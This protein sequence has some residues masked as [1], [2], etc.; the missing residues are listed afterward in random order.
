MRKFVSTILAM[1][2]ISLSLLMSP[3]AASANEQT[4]YFTVEATS[5]C[6]AHTIS[7]PFSNASI[8]TAN[9]QGAWNNG[10]NLPKVNPNGD[11]S[12]PCDS[13]EFPVPPN[14][15]NELIAYDQTMPPGF[16]LGGGAS[17][18]FEVYPGQRISFCQNDARGTHYDNQG[19]A[20]VF[21]RITTQEPLK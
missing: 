11:F 7:N 10:P 1:V 2:I 5:E 4:F 20:E 13:C 15:I 18:N 12:Q 14:K 3:A 19:S 8:L 9:A 17:M 21:V 6:P 16:T